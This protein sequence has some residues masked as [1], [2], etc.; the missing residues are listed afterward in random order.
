MSLGD[1]MIIQLLHIF[2]VFN[3]DIIEYH[4]PS[5]Y[6]PDQP[7]HANTGWLYNASEW[8]PNSKGLQHVQRDTATYINTDS[9]G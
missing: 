9:A 8:L 4:K 1:L 3:N 5:V 2:D 6:V 7:L